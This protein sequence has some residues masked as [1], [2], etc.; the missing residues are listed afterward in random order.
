MAI[1]FRD[2]ETGFEFGKRMLDRGV[3]VSG[4]LVNARM[5]R[6]EPPLTITE[7]QADYVCQALGESLNAMASISADR[8]IRRC[9]RQR[10]RAAHSA[11]E[12]L[13][14]LPRINGVIPMYVDG[15]WRLAADGGTRELINPSNGRTSRPSPRPTWPMPKRRFAAARRAFDEGPWARRARRSRRAA[16]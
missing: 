13:R 1:E 10:I 9:K 8:S 14:N 15:G 16:L 2:H 6:V 12:I 3:L 4:T 5:I 7:E 11:E